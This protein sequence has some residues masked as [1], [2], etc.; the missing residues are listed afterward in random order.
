MDTITGIDTYMIE[1]KR[2]ASSPLDYDNLRTLGIKLTQEF[3][4]DTWTDYNLHDPGLTILEYLCYAITDLAYRTKFKPEDILT[5]N[6]EIIGDGRREGVI[7]GKKN[8]FIAARQIL[9]TNPVSVNDYRK[10]II[11]HFP[12]IENVWLEPFIPQTP[13]SYCKGLFRI[14][15]QY[16]HTLMHDWTQKNERL[17]EA[18]RTYIR[19]FVNEHRNLGDLFTEIVLLEPV[20][21]RIKANI[22]VRGNQLPELIMAEVYETIYRSFNPEIKFYSEAEMKQTGLSAEEINHG[23]FLISGFLK[24]ENLKP[25]PQ[26]IDT[27]DIAKA[28]AGIKGVLLVKDFSI[29]VNGKEYEMETFKIN[30]QPNKEQF[31]FFDY[32]NG[33]HDINLYQEDF[34]MPVKKESF[35]NKLKI[36]LDHSF[37]ET[38]K[39]NAKTTIVKPKTNNRLTGLGKYRKLDQYVSIQYL[40]PEIYKLKR[41]IDELEKKKGKSDPSEIA[42]IKQLKA[43]LMLFEQVMANYLAQLSNIDN[44]FSTDIDED[45]AQTYFFKPV[46]DAPGADK[47]IK[48]FTGETSWKEFK[49]QAGNEYDLFLR[50]KIESDS[51]F[52]NRKNRVFDHVLSRFNIS[53]NIYPLKLY[54]E[55]YDKNKTEGRLTKLLLWKKSLLDNIVLLLRNRSQAYNYS[56]GYDIKHVGGFQQLMQQLLYIGIDKDTGIAN[57]ELRRLCPEF[58]ATGKRGFSFAA[59]SGSKQPTVDGPLLFKKMKTSFF[60]DGLNTDHYSI[61]AGNDGK[62]QILKFKLPHEDDEQNVGKFSDYYGAV[63][64]RD[65]FIEYLRRINTESEGFHLV[66]HN[67]LLPPYDESIS[68]FGF[69][70]T[71]EHNNVVCRHNECTLYNKRNE[72]IIK[73]LTAAQKDLDSFISFLEKESGHICKFPLEHDK[74]PAHFY[75]ISMLRHHY[76]NKVPNPQ[77][78]LRN[79][80]SDIKKSLMGIAQKE[81]N[82]KSKIISLVKYANEDMVEEDFFNF[83]LTVVLPAW[84]A[85]FQDEK[86][87]DYVNKLF[88]E[89]APAQIRLNFTWLNFQKMKNFETI[90]FDW[91]SEMGK[92][93]ASQPSLELSNH[94]IEWLTVNGNN[95]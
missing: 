2:V 88:I 93:K 74:N 65:E 86:F 66:E 61:K 47:I 35:I 55:L 43:Y 46:Y 34:K 56:Q 27:T 91:L 92:D 25:R 16:R 41:N 19:Q 38:A 80:F 44:I 60:S 81:N 50:R 42:A 31:L 20:K 69:K 90:Y 17:K 54:Q 33:E 15:V 73:L 67:L 8:H 49:E 11:D 29:T 64:A 26:F 45:K 1:K 32:D 48:D 83:R 53:L 36:K 62:T 84:P 37:D 75:N 57:T 40:F 52:L 95:K 14:L 23:P 6:E 89:N 68:S 12:E 79:L 76:K 94:M 5:S 87:R 21:V 9:S 70:V 13:A 58:S 59:D 10:L 85:R 72:N 4:A 82:S 22:L 24:D 78:A 18:E 71:N 63:K 39:K 7:D 51:V 30:T 3:S 77:E 28:I